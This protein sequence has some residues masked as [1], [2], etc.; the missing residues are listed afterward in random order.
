MT[1]A[2]DA[3]VPYEIEEQ[4]AVLEYCDIWHMP[5]FHVNNEMWTTSW[6]QKNTAKRLG[7]KSGVPDLFVFVPLGRNTVT[8]EP[9][10]KLITI[11]MK[12]RKGSSTSETQKEWGRI[13]N[14]AAIPH[15]VCKGATE[16]I[17]FIKM[18]QKYYGKAYRKDQDTTAG[19]IEALNASLEGSKS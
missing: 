17:N 5:H 15:A 8:N 18:A 19:F 4:E 7:T 3:L 6:K 9:A 14:Q 1:K 10:Y 12:R 11:E 2:K 16:A 13:F